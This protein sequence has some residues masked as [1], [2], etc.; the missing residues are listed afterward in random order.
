MEREKPQIMGVTISEGKR[1]MMSSF[2]D[3]FLTDER[4]MKVIHIGEEKLYKNYVKKFNNP[5]IPD[6]LL[7]P[8]YVLNG[9]NKALSVVEAAARAKADAAFDFLTENDHDIDLP[10]YIHINDSLWAVSE[11]GT[12][13]ITAINK[14]ANPHKNG[15]DA[16]RLSQFF[17]AWGGSEFFSA[18]SNIFIDLDTGEKQIINRSLYI[19]RV[20]KQHRGDLEEIFAE[21]FKETGAFDLRFIME[22]GFIDVDNTLKYYNEGLP[23]EYNHFVELDPKEVPYE[24]LHLAAHGFTPF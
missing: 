19:G 11:D 14:A 23:G 4:L 8:F 12:K 17:L 7:F 2:G 21:R 13:L 5:S 9:Q 10:P 18:S 15:E 3:Q 22:S 16:Q 1:R 20:K 24:R 6:G